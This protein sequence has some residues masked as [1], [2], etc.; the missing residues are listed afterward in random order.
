MVT[1]RSFLTEATKET[2]HRA[3]R[4]GALTTQLLTDP[5]AITL[6]RWD[7]SAG[8][9]VD[10]VTIQ[11]VKIELANQQEQV[12]GQNTGRVEI[13]NSGTFTVLGTV[14]ARRDDRF[15]LPPYVDIGNG[16]MRGQACRVTLVPPTG[17]VTQTVHF[18]Y[19]Q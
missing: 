18:A 13:V 16:E 6:A 7:A 11:P 15:T 5:P 14:D 9:P 10:Y 3:K 4:R 8:R 1:D 2:I 17:P 19:L 12:S